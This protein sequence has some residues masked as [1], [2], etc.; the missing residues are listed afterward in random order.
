M[1]RI[2]ALACRWLAA[3]LLLS[4]GACSCGVD[5]GAHEVEGQ[6]PTSLERRDTTGPASLSLKDLR[7]ADLPCAREEI[8]A[9]WELPDGALLLQQRLGQHH[10]QYAYYLYHGT[11]PAELI[12][13]GAHCARYEGC[14]EGALTFLCRGSE[15]CG[16]G[17]HP[18]RLIYDLYNDDTSEEPLFLPV[19]QSCAWRHAGE[20]FALTLVELVSSSA[21]VTFDLAP[22]PGPHDRPE[23][24]L[25]PRPVIVVLPWDHG[26]G[27]PGLRLRVYGA[28]L[29]DAMR[30]RWGGVFCRDGEGDPFILQVGVSETSALEALKGDREVLQQEYPYGLWLSSEEVES[31]KDQPVVEVDLVVRGAREYTLRSASIDGDQSESVRRYS[32]EFH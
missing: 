11:G 25:R 2:R 5:R 14:A 1:S 8:S 10:W 29:D 4:C 19:D 13:A 21:G 20:E 32:L 30:G 24:S 15:A 9:E 7:D 16:E 26:G 27:F 12:V 18:Y 3:L 22:P 17:A 6:N 23:G 31:L 28:S